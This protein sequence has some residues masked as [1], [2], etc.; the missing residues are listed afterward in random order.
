[1]SRKLLLYVRVSDSGLRSHLRKILKV[2]LEQHFPFLLPIFF[3]IDENI[4]KI[5]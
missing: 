3:L 2:V 1:M 4:P 5:H